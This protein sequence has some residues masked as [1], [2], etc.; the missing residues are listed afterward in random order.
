MAL[1]MLVVTGRCASCERSFSE[2]QDALD[3]SGLEKRYLVK[4]FILLLQQEILLSWSHDDGMCFKCSSRVLQNR[5][6]PPRH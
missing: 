2:V 4:Y 6:A 1:E 5:K 3:S